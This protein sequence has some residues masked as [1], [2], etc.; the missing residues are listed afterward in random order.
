MRD[1]VKAERGGAVVVRSLARWID[2]AEDIVGF[3][4]SEVFGEQGPLVSRLVWIEL[5]FESS[6]R[7]SCL[8]PTQRE[9]LMKGHCL[10]ASIE[11]VAT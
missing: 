11:A 10:I 9:G 8:P 3:A 1:V 4:R 7:H 6:G 2:A 5:S